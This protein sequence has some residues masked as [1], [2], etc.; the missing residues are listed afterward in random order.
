V[1]TTIKFYAT[2]LVLGLPAALAASLLAA[3][4]VDGL[5]TS[6]VAAAFGQAMCPALVLCTSLKL[7]CEASVLRHLGSRH[8][9]PLKR[10]AILMTGELARVTVGRFVLGFVGGVVLPTLLHR[11]L[12]AGEL[13]A[14]RQPGLLTGVAVSLALLF[15]GELMER[16]LFFTAVVAPKMPGAPVS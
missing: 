9:T 8:H 12:A 16:Y 1:A 10:T 15:V 7:L 2:A 13:P 4:L 11:A 3:L 14:I 6:A 5:S